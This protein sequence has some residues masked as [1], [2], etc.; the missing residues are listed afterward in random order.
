MRAGVV[1]VIALAIGETSRAQARCPQSTLPAYAHNDYENS[2]PLSEALELG[3]RGIEAD[4]FLVN[5]R[6]RLGHDRRSAERGRTLEEV[7]LEPLRNLVEQCGTLTADR[8]PFLIA[9]E[10]KEK[11]PPTYSFLLELLT[12]YRSLFATTGAGMSAPLEAVLVGWHPSVRTFRPDTDGLV[13]VQH[14]I[15]HPEGARSLPADEWIRLISVDYRKTMGRRWTSQTHR[16]RWL[17]ALREIKR[18]APEKLLRVHNVPPD[19]TIYAV[20]LDTGVDLIG[21][22]DLSTTRRLLQAKGVAKDCVL[23]GT[24]VDGLTRWRRF[25]APH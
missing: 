10:L 5:G 15:L 20:L 13:R 21:T 4:V 11:S 2:R 3:L 7:Y 14:R 23:A 22:T 9:I 8:R 25:R 12:R 16:T 17:S 1:F 18:A 24:Q 6:I 19:R